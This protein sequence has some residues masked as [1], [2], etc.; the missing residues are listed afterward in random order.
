MVS[1]SF[2]FRCWG[3]ARR[4]SSSLWRQVGLGSVE[5]EQRRVSSVQR[6]RPASRV[7]DC[8]S[9]W[10]SGC[11][12]SSSP[13][14]LK[15]SKKGSCWRVWKPRQFAVSFQRILLFIAIASWISN[16]LLSYQLWA[17][18][19]LTASWI[20]V[21]SSCLRSCLTWSLE[22][23]NDCLMWSGMGTKWSWAA[24]FSVFFS[25]EGTHQT[26]TYLDDPISWNPDRRTS[27]QSFPSLMF[28]DVFC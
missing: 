23:G 28:F 11:R 26:Q 2:I 18:H 14:S 21:R 10:V 1:S 20:L 13:A 5:A 16:P 27:S 6:L 15:V 12:F 8:Q 24:W 19:S 7:L 4:S 22:R 25:T 9:Q 17:F 3:S